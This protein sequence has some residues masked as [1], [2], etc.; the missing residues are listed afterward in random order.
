MFLKSLQLNL[1]TGFSL[2]TEIRSTNKNQ[3]YSITFRQLENEIFK[4]QLQ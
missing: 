3:L 1:V 2:V 4:C